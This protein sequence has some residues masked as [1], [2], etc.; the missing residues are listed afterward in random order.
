MA[1]AAQ[2]DLSARLRTDEHGLRARL[3]RREALLDVLRGTQ[4]ALDP[5]AVARFLVRWAPA[6]IPAAA[7]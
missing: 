5:A 1:L 6:W 3:E 4:S 2:P 7:G